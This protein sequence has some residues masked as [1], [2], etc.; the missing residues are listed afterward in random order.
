ML[1]ISANTKTALLEDMNNRYSI[2]LTVMS[3]R[4]QTEHLLEGSTY[5][6]NCICEHLISLKIEKGLF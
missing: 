4:L 1:Q 2:K 5:T 6:R 3:I